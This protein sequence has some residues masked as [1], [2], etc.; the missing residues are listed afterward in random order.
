M[1]ALSGLIQATA[2]ICLLPMV[3]LAAA[4]TYFEGYSLSG[5]PHFPDCHPVMGIAESLSRCI[6]V[7]IELP[8]QLVR[9]D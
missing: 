4:R 5:A 2:W 8:H 7:K 3:L 9:P 1:I 6:S